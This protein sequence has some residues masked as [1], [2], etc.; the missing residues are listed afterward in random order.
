M[1][2]PKH[3]NPI[4]L[5]TF[6]PSHSPYDSLISGNEGFV[7]IMKKEKADF[8]ACLLLGLFFMESSAVFLDVSGYCLA[9]DHRGRD[10]IVC[11]AVFVEDMNTF[12]DDP[13]V[14][15]LSMLFSAGIHHS[16]PIR[17]VCLDCIPSVF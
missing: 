5:F 17:E 15:F 7:V 13:I 4:I 14:L 12:G 16:N 11:V 2:Q 6:L 9:R 1:P 10:Y 3:R 8:R